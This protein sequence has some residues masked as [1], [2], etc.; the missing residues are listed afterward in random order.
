LGTEDVVAELCRS[1]LKRAENPIFKTAARYC[2]A[3]LELAIDDQKRLLVISAGM[4][5]VGEANGLGTAEFTI[6]GPHE[7]WQRL[8]RGEID[9]ANAIHAVHG[10]LRLGGDLPK[11]ASCMYALY[12]LFTLR[13]GLA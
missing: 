2:G 5:L 4:V 6:S 12:T 8:L 10:R 7:E 13:G 1:L 3:K 9:F 11:A